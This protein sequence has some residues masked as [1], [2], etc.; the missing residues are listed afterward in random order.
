MKSNKLLRDV[1]KPASAVHA[2]KCEAIALP[3]FLWEI[4]LTWL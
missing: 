1:E 2:R 4:S 3:W